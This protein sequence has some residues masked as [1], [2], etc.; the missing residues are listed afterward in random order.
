MSAAGPAPVRDL[1][2]GGDARILF[3]APSRRLSFVEQDLA[4]LGE[5]SR[6][7]V[8]LREDLP[9]RH[10]LPWAVL[11]RLATRAYGLLFVW[12]AEPYDAPYLL[13]AAR[14]LGVPSAV[15]VGG[16]ELAALPALGYGVLA[17]RGGRLQVRLAL[18]LAG[19]VLPTSELL[20]A[21]ARRLGCRRGI[22]VI[23][24][25]IDCGF[26]RP[27]RGAAA[28]RERLVVTVA[29]LAEPTW[30]VKGL[31]LFAACSRLLPDVRFAVL[32]PCLDPGVA[33]RL[34]SLGGDNLRIDGRRLAPAELRAWYRRAAVYAQLSARESFGIAAAEA[35][36]CECAPVVAAIGG[37][38]ELVGEAGLLV[39]PGDPGA[40]AQAI[41]RAI[42]GA[43]AHG[44]ARAARQRIESRFGSARRRRALAGAVARLLGEAPA[45]RGRVPRGAPAAGGGR[46]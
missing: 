39:P 24:P 30:R 38:P 45:A 5:L 7:D 16:Y 41:A 1:A 10:Q 40:A 42:E 13:L 23:P 44:P 3:V 9:A 46:A 4:T 22:E 29:T 35:M 25:G 26:F 32:G 15:V 36:A 18:A 6:V 31:D 37:L 19:A 33:A 28:P 34:R 2:G 20:A 8:L 43:L 21:E 12:F 17:S 27:A 11:R 14:L